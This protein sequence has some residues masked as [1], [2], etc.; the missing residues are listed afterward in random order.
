MDKTIKCPNCG[1]AFDNIENEFLECSHCGKKYKNPFYKHED[2][3]EQES[4]HEQQRRKLNLL[5]TSPK[6]TTTASARFS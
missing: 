1:E 3:L 4:Q 6:S 2:A 5:K